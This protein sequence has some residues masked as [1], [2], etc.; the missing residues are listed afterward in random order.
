MQIKYGRM[1]VCDCG[2]ATDELNIW[3]PYL[4]YIFTNT[5]LVGQTLARV[6]IA[7]RPGLDGLMG[8]SRCYSLD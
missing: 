8:P 5:S 4:P 6:R 2:V 1:G 3:E 7:W